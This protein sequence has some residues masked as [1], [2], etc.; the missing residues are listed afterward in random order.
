MSTF[1]ES[2]LLIETA[3]AKVTK[4]A[5]ILALFT[6]KAE[7]ID[8]QEGEYDIVLGYMCDRVT[9]ELREGEFEEQL[10]AARDFMRKFLG[11][12]K[13]EFRSTWNP[14]GN[15]V[16][17]SWMDKDTNIQLWCTCTIDTFPKSMYPSEK[18]SWIEDPNANPTK[19]LVCEL[20]GE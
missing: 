17:I 16:N 12:W 7:L 4:A 8:S 14:Y 6:D 9:F 15:I 11:T 2:E 5:E 3:A 10:T 18:C 1:N 19:S 20:P 13:D